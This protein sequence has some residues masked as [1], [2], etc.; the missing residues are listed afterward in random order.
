MQ[1]N[2]L[3][4]AIFVWD[5]TKNEQNWTNEVKSIFYESN[6]GNIFD[7][8]QLFPLKSVVQKMQEKMLKTQQ[9]NLEIE[10]LNKPKLRTF[11]TFKKFHE[12]PAY[13]GKPLSFFQRRVLAKCRLGCLSI[14][15]ETGRYSR[16]RLLENERTCQV[17]VNNVNDYEHANEVESEI[18]LLFNC[19]RYDDLRKSW[20]ENLTLSIDYR[21]LNFYEKLDLVLNHPEN[22]KLT[23]QFLINALDLR[24]KI[25]IEHRQ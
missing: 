4:K 15:L 21:L 8:E 6:Q 20:L 2:R 23:A 3:A 12:P 24:S 25:L 17:C 5:K 7:S 22:V 14:R 13:V 9:S 16:P 11:I 1:D 18:H 19:N 10:C